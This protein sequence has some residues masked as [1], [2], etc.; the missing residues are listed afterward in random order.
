ML[1]EREE[2]RRQEGVK[3][4]ILSYVSMDTYRGISGNS[5][6]AYIERIVEFPVI[7]WEKRIGLLSRN[8]SN[9]DSRF[10]EKLLQEI[11]VRRRRAYFFYHHIKIR[12]QIAI[13][14][15]HDVKGRILKNKTFLITRLANY[16]TIFCGF[17]ERKKSKGSC[18]S[19]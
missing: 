12:L 15:R 13:K 19:T 3:S 8:S 11:V 18:R 16:R 2:S 4:E 1:S 14:T 7:A 9:R 17:H 6:T 10:F 5:V